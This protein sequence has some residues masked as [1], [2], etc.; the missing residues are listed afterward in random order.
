MAKASKESRPPIPGRRCVPEIDL[1]ENHRRDIVRHAW[2]IRRFAAIAQSLSAASTAS[3]NSTPD[4]PCCGTKRRI[5]E[6]SRSFGFGPE[7]RF[8][9]GEAPQ[10]TAARLPGLTGRFSIILVGAAFDSCDQAASTSAGFSG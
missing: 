8:M 10:N 3:M 5:F 2:D 1:P 7:D 9:L 4:P 6:F